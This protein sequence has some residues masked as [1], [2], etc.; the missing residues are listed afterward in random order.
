MAS[1]NIKVDV[2]DSVPSVGEYV[3]KVNT[4]K[5][6]EE[7]YVFFLEAKRDL[8]E[9]DYKV[10]RKMTLSQ[11]DLLIECGALLTQDF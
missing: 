9:E 3:Q 8:K 2:W 11:F 6:P 10:F 4:A 1:Q 7:L 5:G